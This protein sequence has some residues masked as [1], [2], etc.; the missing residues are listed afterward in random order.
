MSGRFAG[1][2]AVVVGAGVAGRGRGRAPSSQEGAQVRSATR[3][4]PRI[5]A[6]RRAARARGSRCAA[7]G[8][9]PGAPRRRDARR[10]ESRR[11]AS[12]RRSSTWARERGIPVWGEMELGARLCDVPVHR[13]HRHERQDHDDRH[14]RVVSA[15]RRPR[16]RRVRQ[17]RPPVPLAAARGARRARRGG[18]SFQLA[19]QES[20][21]PKVSVLLNLAPDH[22]DWHGSVRGL[23]RRQANLVYAQ[24]RADDVHV[25]NRDDPIARPRSP[26][27]PRARWSGSRRVHRTTER[28]ATSTGSWSRDSTGEG[29]LGLGRRRARRIPRRCRR[30]GRR[31]ARRSASRR[32]RSARAGGFVP[33]RH[34]GEVVATVDGVR[35]V[36]NSKATNVHAALAA[37]DGVESAVLIAGGRA[38]GVDL[39]PLRSRSQ[40]LTGVVAIGES[41]HEIDGGVRRTSCRSGVRRRSR[42][43]RGT[44]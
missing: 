8:H 16:R 4:P 41:A 18:S 31:R 33:A 42:R 34:R 21:H 29:V 27:P 24:A 28:S 17:H 30:R 44:R 5:G 9:E 36:D 43:R 15:R 37:L 35:F 20:F 10:H 25:G 39:S 40:R 3:A 6:V 14:D 2:R 11:A 19:L 23:R 22:L 1:E 13:R 12:A 32:T 26:R 38:K 7:G